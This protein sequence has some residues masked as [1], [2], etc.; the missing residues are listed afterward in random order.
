ML[1]LGISYGNSCHASITSNT[2][3]IR[4]SHL[5]VVHHYFRR[6]SLKCMKA[7]KFPFHFHS[8]HFKLSSALKHFGG[9]EEELSY[10]PLG[11]TAKVGSCCE[12]WTLLSN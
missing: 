10:L 4:I 1:I 5:E 12:S 8:I 7:K 6:R 9:R 11:A 2:P 3:L